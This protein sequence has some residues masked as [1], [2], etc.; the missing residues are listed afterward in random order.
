VNF[1]SFK[2]TAVLDFSK[3]FWHY[4]DSLQ[5]S[6]PSTTS[7]HEEPGTRLFSTILATSG[8]SRILEYSVRGSTEYSTRAVNSSIRTALAMKDSDLHRNG[9]PMMIN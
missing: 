6:D 5:R 1:A 3:H 4:F 2:F 7:L 9:R 8:I